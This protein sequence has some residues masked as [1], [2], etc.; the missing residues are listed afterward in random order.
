MGMLHR[1]IQFFR[2]GESSTQMLP[3]LVHITVVIHPRD[4][5]V[6]KIQP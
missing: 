4:P 3:E 1:D 2:H 5:F 6:I